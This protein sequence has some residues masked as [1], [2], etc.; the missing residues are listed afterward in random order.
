MFEEKD[1]QEAKK[2]NT[3]HRT[4]TK[5]KK[6]LGRGKHRRTQEGKGNRNTNGAA[7]A[8]QRNCKSEGKPRR[9]KEASSGH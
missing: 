9:R 7:V 3:M 2:V 1:S 6:M 4:A 8:V 5:L